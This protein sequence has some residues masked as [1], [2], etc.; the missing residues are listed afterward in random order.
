[1]NDVDRNVKRLNDWVCYFETSVIG[2][3][4]LSR[5]HSVMVFQAWK[6]KCSNT[7][8]FEFPRSS[9]CYPVSGHAADRPNIVFIL[10]DD[11]GYGDIKAFA[12]VDV[13]LIHL[14]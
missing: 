7:A 9:Q 1:M 4:E 12:E 11:L 3:N 13:I 2:D 5:S 14:I 8:D 10:A 6:R